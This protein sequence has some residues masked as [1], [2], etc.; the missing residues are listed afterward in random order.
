MDRFL[1]NIGSLRAVADRLDKLGLD[2][3][4]VGGSIVSFLLDNPGLSPVRATDDVDVI[5]EVLATLRYSVVE[6][7]LR[8][9]QFDHDM[10]PGAPMCRWKLGT[11]TVDIMPT[12]GAHLGL[13]TRWFCE[14][15]ETAAPRDIGGTPLRLISPVAFL[16]TKYVAFCDRGGADYYGSHDLEDFITVVDGRANIV[17]EID[18]ASKP[19][20][21]FLVEAIRFLQKADAF[22]DALAGHLP[23]D[24]A[25]QKRLPML[26][27][28]LLAIE[29]LATT[30]PK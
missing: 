8:A 5:L 27:A 1:P 22:N 20:R 17:A 7:K 10:T 4:F 13:N 11:L 23:P 24:G 14:A 29:K 6:E 9:L 26:R 25:S 2:Y 3:A 12:D 28:K 15:L 21:K 19:L 16:A 18:S 30:S